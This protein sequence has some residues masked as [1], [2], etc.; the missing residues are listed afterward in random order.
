HFR[1]ALENLRRVALRVHGDRDEI[2]FR[3]KRRPE[4]ILDVGHFRRQQGTGVR[5]THIDEGDCKHF[6]AQILKREPLTVLLRE[7]ELGRRL[8]LWE[9]V[10]SGGTH[11]NSKRENNCDAGKNPCM[12]IHSYH[13]TPDTY[14]FNSFFS[15]L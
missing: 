8:D 12:Y 6:A 7:R 15:S 14:A 13:L 2:N 10:A 4:P 1:V 11:R 3:A 9:A 5:A